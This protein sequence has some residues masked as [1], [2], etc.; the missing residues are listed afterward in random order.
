MTFKRLKVHDGGHLDR[1]SKYLVKRIEKQEK[2]SIFI[3]GGQRLERE[4]FP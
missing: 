4:L 1:N 3:F 2:L